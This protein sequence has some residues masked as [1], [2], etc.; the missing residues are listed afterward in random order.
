MKHKTLVLSA[1]ALAALAACAGT[2]P[3]FQRQVFLLP[4]RLAIDRQANWASSPLKRAKPGQFGNS[5][6]LIFEITILQPAS[7]RF[8]RGRRG[9]GTI[10][11]TIHRRAK[12]R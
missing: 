8:H 5:T 10:S 6:A 1:I 11:P 4:A 2:P 7:P 9:L 3:L 12:S